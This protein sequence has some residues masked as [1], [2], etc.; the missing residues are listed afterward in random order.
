M[1]RATP[2]KIGKYEIIKELGRGATS[3]VYLATDAFG[4]R[5]V[6]I[7]VIDPA[8]LKD[9]HA[10]R[11]YRKQLTTEAALAGKLVHPHIVPIYDAVLEEDTGYIVMEY[12]GGGTLEKFATMDNLLRINRVLEIGFKCCKALEFAERHGII[13]RD[14]KPGNILLTPTGDIKISDFG[15]ALVPK[16]DSTQVTG[17]GSPGYMSPEQ[18]Q[19]Q[20][21]THQSDIYSLGVV[22]YQLLTGRL[23]FQ[24]SNPASMIYQI[25]NI[26]PPR[27]R[28]LRAELPEEL[29][30]IV[31]RAMQK[32]PEARYPGW[33]DFAADLASI[34]N[35]D[36]TQ[37]KI[38][39]TE[40]FS[41]LKAL[42]FFKSFSDVELWEVTRISAW[43][44][45]GPGAV[46][47]QEGSP[48]ISF[49]ILGSGEVRV[50]K[51]G[52]PLT[53]LRAGDPFGEMAY[54]GRP[55]T[56]RTA[57]V[58]AVTDVTVI[59]IDAPALDA[60]TDNCQLAFNQT[61]LRILVERL[62]SASSRISQLLS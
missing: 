4:N 5:E 11:F 20:P 24:A 42:S 52:R 23:P 56:L 54:L 12:V 27:P 25:V 3:I 1:D 53:T 22:L 45:H 16:T 21:L 57:T 50:T 31:L 29:E 26:G 34:G 36:D 17:I 61:F 8:A 10:G 55:A 13:H 44:R 15:S 41:T 2:V 47:L 30:K 18:V 40:K 32:R 46:L 59:K 6:A 62:S 49:F 33:D 9:P 38:S 7:K 19:E 43:S 60:A 58:T 51:E 28:D 39:D 35:I 14:I 37:R 48:G